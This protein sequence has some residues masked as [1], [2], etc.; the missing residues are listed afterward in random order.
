MFVYTRSRS[1]TYHFRLYAIA[2]VQKHTISICMQSLTLRNIPFQF[3]CNRL[4]SETYHFNL[5]TTAYVQKHTISICIH[6]LTF[7]NMPFQFVYT[8]L[9][10]QFCLACFDISQIAQKK[11]LKYPVSMAKKTRQFRQYRHFMGKHVISC[12]YKRFH[13]NTCVFM[14]NAAGRFGF[15][16]FLILY[17]L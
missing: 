10:L 6:P 12:K 4:R 2:Y 3:V 17:L 9:R 15:Y 5:Y 14:A 8:R 11:L 16:F 13:A 7:R 1:E